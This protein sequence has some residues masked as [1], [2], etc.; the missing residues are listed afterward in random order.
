MRKSIIA[1]ICGIVAIV[2]IAVAAFSMGVREGIR[3]AIEDSRIDAEGSVV[4]V[5]LDGEVY[6]HYI[7]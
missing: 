7:D 2:C 6:E 3:H 1:A 4:F 5:D